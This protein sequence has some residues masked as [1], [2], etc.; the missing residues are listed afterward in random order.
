MA[1]PMR[2]V[3]CQ[4]FVRKCTNALPAGLTYRR[5]ASTSPPGSVHNKDDRRPKVSMSPDGSTLLCWHPAMEFPY[6]HTKP[7]PRKI[8][9]LAE[10]ESVLK[11]QYLMSEKLKHREDG[12]T[13]KELA[14]IFFTS[15]HRWYPQPQKKYRKVRTPKD[16]DRI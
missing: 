15:K 6:Q 10:G 11:V 7:I 13:D 12:P 2:S 8:E 5:V 14:N 16:R 4:M 1:A 3:F 9:E